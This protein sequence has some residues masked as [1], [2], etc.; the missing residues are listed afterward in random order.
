MPSASEID[1]L[2]EFTSYDQGPP[3]T[4]VCPECSAVVVNREDHAA[5]HDPPDVADRLDELALRQYLRGL[6]ATTYGPALIAAL[7][8]IIRRTL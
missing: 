8:R 4:Y 3:R 2:I 5:W 6:H 1:R 7:D